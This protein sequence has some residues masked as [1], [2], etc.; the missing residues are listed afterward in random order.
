[1]QKDE[2]VVDAAS[3][4]Y[5]IFRNIEHAPDP[6]VNSDSMFC[7]SIS[8]SFIYSVEANLSKST[9]S[10]S[11]IN[12][13]WPFG[14]FWTK[15]FRPNSLARE[16]PFARYPILFTLPETVAV[17]LLIIFKCEGLDYKVILP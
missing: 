6:F 16:S 2:A 15:P 11:A 4:D 12:R 10:P 5:L 8:A 3:C 14:R 7:T 1:V 17:S 13:I 9:I